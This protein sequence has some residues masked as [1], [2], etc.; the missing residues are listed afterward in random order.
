MSIREFKDLLSWK[1]KKYFKQNNLQYMRIL[2]KTHMLHKFTSYLHDK[3]KKLRFTGER[4]ASH[5]AF[6][7]QCRYCNVSSHATAGQPNAKERLTFSS[8]FPFSGLY[9]GNSSGKWCDFG[10][11]I[12]QGRT[13]CQP[14]PPSPPPP[15][16]TLPIECELRKISAVKTGWAQQMDYLLSLVLLLFLMNKWLNQ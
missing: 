9:E 1:K 15:W 10:T 3:M 13:K 8:H 16:D 14:P 2:T 11:N 7:T 6:R 12:S 5:S 4:L